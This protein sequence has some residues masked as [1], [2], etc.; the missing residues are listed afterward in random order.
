MSGLKKMT[1]CLLI[2]FCCGAAA[3]HAQD[4]FNITEV[5]RYDYW[6]SAN[7]V[8]ATGI[9]VYLSTGSTGVRIIDIS[10][11]EN[12]SEIGNIESIY[13]PTQVYIENNLLYVADHLN[14]ITV[15][16]LMDPGSPALISRYEGEHDIVYFK[17]FNSIAYVQNDVDV[18]QIIDF[19][20]PEN[21]D[22]S[23][24]I[25]IT[26]QIRDIEFYEQFAY[27]F[28]GRLTIL[29]LSDITDPNLI[30]IVDSDG[31]SREGA[32]Y[33]NYLYQSTTLGVYTVDITNPFSPLRVGFMRTEERLARMIVEGDHLYASDA[34]GN[35]KIFSLENP[36]QIMISHE[37]FAGHVTEFVLYNNFILSPQGN[38][39]FFLLDL[40]DLINE[41]LYTINLCGY[42]S[43]LYQYENYLYVGTRRH[44][45]KVYDIS[46]PAIP[47]ELGEIASEISDPATFHQQ[48]GYYPHHQ[49][50]IVIYD[51]SNPMSPEW[52]GEWQLGNYYFYDIE[53]VFPYIYILTRD[54]L[55]IGDITDPTNPELIT[56][57]G[58]PNGAINI[59]IQGDFAYVAASTNGMIILDISDPEVPEVLGEFSTD[60]DAVEVGI[61]ENYAFVAYDLTGLFIVD[62]S[63]PTNPVEVRHIETPSAYGITIQDHHAFV[64]HRGLGLYVYDIIEPLNPVLV[65]L[66]DAHYSINDVLLSGNY[67]ILPDRWSLDFLDV[68]L[69]TTANHLEVPLSAN[70]FE[71]VSTPY[72]PFNRNAENIFGDIEN[73]VIAIA[74]NGEFFIPGFN[75]DWNIDIT[76]GYQ[77]YTEDFSAWIPIGQEMD[78]A[79]E[80]SLQTA[81]WN[82]LGHPFTA[83]VAVEDAL[84]EVA[85]SIEIMLDDDGNMWIPN[86][87]PQPVNTLGNLEPGEG[88]Y[89]FVN[90]DINFHYGLL[91]ELAV[92]NRL[93]TASNF[94]VDQ[95]IQ[96]NHSSLKST[97]KPYAILVHFDKSLSAMNPAIVE[98][99]DGDNLVGCSTFEI[100]GGTVIP[101]VAWEGDSE[102]KLNGFVPG[103]QIYAVVKDEAGNIVADNRQQ[104]NNTPKFGDAPY[105][106]IRVTS[107]ESEVAQPTAFTVGKSYPNPFNSQIN[108]PF[109][110]PEKSDVKIALF[111][112]LGQEQYS[113][114]KVFEPGHH[115]FSIDSNHLDSNF[116]SGIYFLKVQSN[117]T[118]HTQKVILLQ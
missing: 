78:I 30:A 108:V 20:N 54:R 86:A 6:D 14:G 117:G 118:S 9:F 31:S 59:T 43:T 48:Y 56:T 45:I 109:S 63:E 62:I 112:V 66:F 107:V 26:G 23:G 21:P 81:Q 77:L 50:G 65:G 8:A 15:Y 111:N 90:Q 51:F 37:V 44:P 114:A 47:V 85:E 16:S 67:A 99:Y 113:L 19:G 5:A 18:L 89:T 12:L 7:Y 25:E 94:I 39:G 106:E 10:N 2:L 102:R 42:A 32:I 96:A 105:A 33:D 101:L 72:I 1:V 110:L 68:S 17:L 55:I 73:L 98:L 76:N 60:I 35:M 53:I 27:V 75:L 70:R 115:R 3:S 41:E 92:W 93:P 34:V 38:N 58:I 82:W 13:R 57:R 116:G 71:L 104:L 36:E 28:D 95:S 88:Y 22:P 91:A 79:W 29:D 80:Y 52:T 69:A 87:E 24:E 49:S 40:G 97:G 83:E 84:A 100:N 74:N 4:N 64:P 11:P 61:Y 103:N 46:I